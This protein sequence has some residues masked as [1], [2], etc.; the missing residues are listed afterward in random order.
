LDGSD[1]F[2][3]GNGEAYDK[4]LPVATYPLEKEKE[5]FLN[6]EP[7]PYASD[8]RKSFGRYR[9]SVPSGGIR[10]PQYIEVQTG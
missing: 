7:S 9:K 8:D 3:R 4:N 1:W 2:V 10:Y 5:L 6:C